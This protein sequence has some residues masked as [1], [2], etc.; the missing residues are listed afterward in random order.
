LREEGLSLAEIARQFGVSKQAV[1]KKLK[2]PIANE[3]SENM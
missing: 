3:E 2:E 1:F